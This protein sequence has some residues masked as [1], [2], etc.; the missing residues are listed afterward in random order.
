MNTESSNRC[1]RIRF[2]MCLM[3][4]IEQLKWQVLQQISTIFLWERMKAVRARYGKK[5]YK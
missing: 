1:N 5:N 3:L 4:Q 2:P